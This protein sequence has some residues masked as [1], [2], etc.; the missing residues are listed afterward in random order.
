[1]QNCWVQEE[2]VYYIPQARGLVSTINRLAAALR[3]KGG[4]IVW[5]QSTMT[6]TGPGA[7][8]QL[9]AHLTDDGVAERAELIAG[10]PM[11][12]LCTGLDVH[13][14]DCRVAKNRFSAFIEGSSNIEQLLRGERSVDTVLIAGVATHICCESTARDAMMRDFRTVMIEDANAAREEDDHRAGLSTFAQVFG[15]VMSTDE[16]ILRFGRT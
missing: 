16:A 7:W 1:M 11:H 10:H 15:A 12:A 3:A 2:G 5:I 8:P 9:Y 4:T 14:I 13:P 6:A